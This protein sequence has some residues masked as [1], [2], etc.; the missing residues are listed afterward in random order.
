MTKPGLDTVADY[1]APGGADGPDRT[2]PYQAL[3]G[4]VP[5]RIATRFALSGRLDPVSVDLQEAIRDHA[6]APA[7]FDDKTTQLLVFAML[8]ME[9]SDAAVT[10]AIAARRCGASWEELQA[11]VSLC[12]LFRGLPAAN[13]GASMLAEAARHEMA[14]G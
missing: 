13:R 1:M 11:I 4:F 12:F 7:C 8:V 10:H 9:L 6:L 14:A 3:L 2:A 5:P